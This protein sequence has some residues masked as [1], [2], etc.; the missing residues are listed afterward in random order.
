MAP[1]GNRVHDDELITRLPRQFK[2]PWETV[3]AAATPAG[4][5]NLT[6]SWWEPAPAYSGALLSM[7]DRLPGCSSRER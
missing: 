5:N 3:N 2:S 6:G 1:D 7:F 4:I